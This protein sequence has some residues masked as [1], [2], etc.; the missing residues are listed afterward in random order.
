MQGFSLFF[1]DQAGQRLSL[2]HISGKRPS[3]R[4]TMA[5][6]RAKAAE[7]SEAARRA[8]EDAR[9]NLSLIHI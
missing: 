6:I 5:A 1:Q 4:E 2:I 7:A 3:A 8:S 9:L